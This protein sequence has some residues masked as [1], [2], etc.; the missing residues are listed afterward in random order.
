MFR[1]QTSNRLMRCDQGIRDAECVVSVTGPLELLGTIHQSR[2]DWI[3]VDVP[4]ASDQ[5]SAGR[6]EARVE[7]TFPQCAGSPISSVEVAGILPG[8]CVNRA[9][10]ADRIDRGYQQVHMV[11]HQ[12]IAMQGHSDIHRRLGQ[13]VP[14]LQIVALASKDALSIV[15]PMHDVGW[16]TRDEMAMRSWHDAHN[17]ARTFRDDIQDKWCLAPVLG[18]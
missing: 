3:E 9:R 11:W 17:A 13:Q 1:S 5:V 6:H 14:E 10:D 2:P 8:R 16:R 7:S 12:N 4:M 15:P 18:V